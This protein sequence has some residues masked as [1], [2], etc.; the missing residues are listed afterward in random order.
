M[1]ERN[2]LNGT[3]KGLELDKVCT[4]EE[5]VILAARLIEDTYNLLDAG[6]KGFAWKVEH[7]GNIIYFLGSIHIGNSQLYPISQNFG[8]LQRIR[9][10]IVEANL[11]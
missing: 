4:T 5:A 7:N 8:I 3:S 6:S 9:C 11:I 10:L 2:I 1:Q